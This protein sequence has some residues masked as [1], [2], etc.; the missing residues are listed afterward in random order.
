MP[1]RTKI[2]NQLIKAW[3]RTVENDYSPGHINSER[4]LQAL[5]FANL[6]TVLNEEGA[7]RR[8]FVEPTVRLSDGSIIRPDM[9]ICNAREVICI[10]EL[11]YV[12]R[13]KANTDKDMRS[14][15][16][17]AR[18]PGLSVALERYSGS[19]LPPLSFDVSRSVLFAWAGVHC[20]DS[21]P[22]QEWADP[23]FQGHYFLELHA[24]TSEGREPSLR[25]NTNAF[26]VS[27]DD[28]VEA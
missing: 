4:S 15:S 23:A 24:V 18:A 9:M 25:Y 13:G 22:A 10:L 17:I 8:V 28:P 1:R 3:K 26:R 12:P 19:E 2:G 6:R 14:I 5:L 11:K 20:G 7:E 21:E 16:S 27:V